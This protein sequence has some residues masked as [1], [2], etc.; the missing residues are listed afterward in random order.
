MHKD[1][2]NLFF[3]FYGRR[4]S[5]DQCG[6]GQSTEQRNI[7]TTALLG[8]QDTI[9]YNSDGGAHQ[10][11]NA[12]YVR[13]NEDGK[14]VYSLI[15]NTNCMGYE[16]LYGDKY[17]WLSGVSLPNTNAQE[18]YKLLIEMPDGSTRKVKS[19]TVD[20]YCTGM[21]HQKY[22][23]VVGVN[24]QKG[25][26]TTYYCDIFT[27]SGTANRV[28]CRSHNYSNA[29]GGVS[30]AYCGYDSSSTS[31]HIG[32]RLAFRGEIEEAESVTAFKAIKAILA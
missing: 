24:S 13:P 27:P 22:M 32:S 25:S 7:G 1:I 21:Y 9:S 5:Q 28:V 19:G 10:T 23:D 11:S 18:Q 2:A 17:E 20:G 26:S 29:G 3:A 15:Y 16:N 6:Y 30:F 31:S 12:W 4:D 8:M 14:N